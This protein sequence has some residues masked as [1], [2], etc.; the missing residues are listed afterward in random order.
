VPP[1]SGRIPVDAGIVNGGRA[2]WVPAM[3]HAWSSESVCVWSSG[4]GQT[5]RADSKQRLNLIKA[6]KGHPGLGQF[7]PES[8]CQAIRGFVRDELVIR[9]E[10]DGSPGMASALLHEDA[11]VTRSARAS[12][13]SQSM[14][15]RCTAM[16]DIV[17]ETPMRL[18]PDKRSL[19][20]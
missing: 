9:H 3:A 15:C 17:R 8:P 18:A 1:I 19:D 11:R 16:L 10:P 2:R 4:M 12:A 7:L 14:R 6:P 13:R 20:R 5:Q